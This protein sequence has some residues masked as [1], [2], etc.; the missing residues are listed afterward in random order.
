[1]SF[2]AFVLC[3]IATMVLM[4]RIVCIASTL[5][6]SAWSGHPFCFVG[7][8]MSYALA[9]GGAVGY[10]LGWNHGGV[11]L[12]LGAAGWVVFDRRRERDGGRHA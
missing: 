12:L 6:R 8:S 7:L 9:G 10:T 3:S 11:L 2:A 5:S 4:L 1:M